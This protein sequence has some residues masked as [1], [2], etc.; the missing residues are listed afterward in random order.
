MQKLEKF[1]IK[2]LQSLSRKI[3]V[4]CLTMTMKAKASHI[5]SNFSIIEML[6][7]IYF[8]Y[9]NPKKIINN[10]GY[11]MGQINKLG[12]FPKQQYTMLHVNLTFNNFV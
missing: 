9:N 6:I 1:R 12:S 8:I 11:E 7:S 2:Q 4:D 10:R 5:G 3:R